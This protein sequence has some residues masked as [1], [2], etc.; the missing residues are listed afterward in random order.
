[1][2]HLQKCRYKPSENYRT[3]RY[4]VGLDFFYQRAETKLP[5]CLVNYRTPCNPSYIHQTI[6]IRPSS[7]SEPTLARKTDSDRQRHN[8]G[9][10]HAPLNS[11]KQEQLHG[12]AVRV[13]ANL[14]GTSAT[15]AI[16]Y[17]KCITRKCL[18]LKIKSRS[19]STTFTMVPFDGKYQPLQTSYYLS[20][21]R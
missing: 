15:C 5:D 10:R 4:L 7:I 14:L 12:E 13:E 21:F 1:M 2:K 11:H 3:L 6:A 18:T 8:K 19:R 16:F 9:N 20:I 17:S